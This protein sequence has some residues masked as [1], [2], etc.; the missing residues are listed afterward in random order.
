[1]NEK[2]EITAEILQNWADNMEDKMITHYV[3]RLESV[4]R[5]QIAKEMREVYP[6]PS[7]EAKAWAYAY[8]ELIARG[9]ND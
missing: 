8:A 1:M 3:N 5:E 6:H 9:K 4:L 2:Q 7:E